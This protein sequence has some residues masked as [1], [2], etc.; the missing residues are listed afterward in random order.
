[1]WES[2]SAEPHRQSICQGATTSQQGQLRAGVRS[3]CL[4]LCS[5]AQC[6]SSHCH[7]SVTALHCAALH[8]CRRPP[9][10]VPRG[11]AQMPSGLLLSRACAMAAR[12]CQTRSLS[13]L[14]SSPFPYTSPPPLPPPFI[15]LSAV[16][17]Y[18]SGGPAAAGSGGVP[19]G[20]EGLPGASIT[21][22][23]GRGD[24]VQLI[25]CIH[26]FACDACA[27]AWLYP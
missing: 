20:G 14:I 12:T 5:A 24:A 11:A 7:P 15:V 16:A 10:R 6:T 4:A 9:R 2:V 1:M 18:P 19:R 27:H 22:P 26:S 17:A 8:C 3:V 25:H 23:C 21:R 13:F